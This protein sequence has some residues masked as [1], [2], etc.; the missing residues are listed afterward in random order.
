MIE[1]EININANG[2]NL[3]GTICLPNEEGRFPVVIMIHGSGPL[4]RD[5]NMPV[6][7][8]N[9]FN[10]IAHSLVKQGIA[11]LRYDKRGCG[12]S[13]GDYYSAGLFD[14]VDDAVSWFDFA[15]TYEHFDVNKIF[16]LGHS[17]GCIIAPQINIQRQSVAGHILLCPF[18]DKIDSILMKQAAQVEKEFEELTGFGG[19]I[20]KSLGRMMGANVESQKKLID[21][22]KSSDKD[23]MRVM[24]QKVPAKSLRELI[25]LDP[26]TIFKQITRPMLMIG[27]EKDLQCDPADVHKIA[28]LVNAPIEKHVIKNLTHVLRFDEGKPSILETTKLLNKPIEPIVLE[29]IENWLKTKV[30]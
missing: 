7:K 12:K 13:T 16:L 24:L 23:T 26:P 27:G 3:L 14:V 15:T 10:A 18:V 6:Q 28:E 29:T 2:N 4:D 8:L 1:K 21:K 19:F 9:V 30:L 25:S 22:L 17:E 5:E 11:S 20:R